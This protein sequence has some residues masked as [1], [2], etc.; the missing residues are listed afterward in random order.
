MTPDEKELMN[1][2]CGQIAVERDHQK[3]TQLV[4]ELDKLLERKEHRLEQGAE[5]PYIPK[6]QPDPAGL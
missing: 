4:D 2:L 6:R 3:F 5:S 1:K